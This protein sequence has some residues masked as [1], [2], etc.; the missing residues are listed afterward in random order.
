MRVFVCASTRF[1]DEAAIDAELDVLPADATLIQINPQGVD[2]LAITI[3]MRRG[4]PC[5]EETP[6]Y[7]DAFRYG[8]RIWRVL[9]LRVLDTRPDL[10]LAFRQNKGKTITEIVEQAT[11]RGI[12][13][14]VIERR[15]RR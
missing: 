6:E 14:K 2:N 11:G 3:G 8:L 12:A 7:D 1:D 9:M 4:F 5:E 10:V 13:T 15:S